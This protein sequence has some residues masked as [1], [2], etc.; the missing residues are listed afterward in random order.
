MSDELTDVEQ[1]V[2]DDVQE[3][4]VVKQDLS[5]SAIQK[6]L[7]DEIH[8]LRAG[9]IKPADLSAITNAAGKILSTLV[10]ELRFAELT[11]EKPRKGLLKFTEEV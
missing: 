11:G 3:R 7:W 4:D 8:E 2:E 5:M 1:T 9:K 6:V 10:L